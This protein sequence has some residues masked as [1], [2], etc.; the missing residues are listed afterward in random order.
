MP[1]S[2]SGLGL[3]SSKLGRRLYGD[4]STRPSACRF[5][6]PRRSWVLRFQSD[7]CWDSL[8]VGGGLKNRG[9]AFTS[10]ESVRYMRYESSKV[11][12]L[13]NWTEGRYS[14]RDRSRDCNF[15]DWE[16]GRLRSGL[17]ETCEEVDD[18]QKVPEDGDCKGGEEG[19]DLS[20]CEHRR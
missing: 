1:V 4:G 19:G 8:G 16:F 14:F 12:T 2:S 17:E 18:I 13:N 15:S 10:V 7:A 11:L 6:L 5:F 3:D 9:E 20:K